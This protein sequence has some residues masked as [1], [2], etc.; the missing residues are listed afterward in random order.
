MVDMQCGPEELEGKEEQVELAFYPSFI[1]WAAWY[2]TWLLIKIT[3]KGVVFSFLFYMTGL[4]DCTFDLCQ[5][6]VEAVK[7]R[8][9]KEGKMIDLEID[10]LPRSYFMKR[11][12][13]GLFSL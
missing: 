8:K 5:Q 10:S 11:C 6:D 3:P 1:F 4:S 12:V 9:R 7:Q 13:F 2:N